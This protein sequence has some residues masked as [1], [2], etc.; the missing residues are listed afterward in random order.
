MIMKL[1]YYLLFHYFLGKNDIFLLKLISFL[2]GGRE[3]P[4]EK[5]IEKSTFWRNYYFLF[6]SVVIFHFL[7]NFKKIKNK[8][9]WNQSKIKLNRN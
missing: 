1:Q 8:T 5:L 7:F 6:L 2:Y 4:I 9:K 3:L